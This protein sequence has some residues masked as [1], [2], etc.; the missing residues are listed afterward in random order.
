MVIRSYGSGAQ[1]Q[2]GGHLDS[3]GQFVNQ[4]PPPVVSAS[5]RHVNASTRRR[6]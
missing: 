6:L 1:A 2:V 3:H 4:L 5:K